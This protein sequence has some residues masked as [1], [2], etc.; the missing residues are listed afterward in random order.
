MDLLGKP[1]LEGLFRAAVAAAEPGAMVRKALRRS[2]SGLSLTAGGVSSGLDLDDL[3]KIYLVGGGKATR[4]MGEAA[5][6]ILGERVAAGVLAVPRGSGGGKGPVRFVEAGHPLPDE[7][8]RRAAGEM[9]SLLSEAGE[10]D[11][12][13][14]L[15]SGGGSAM[16]SAP[17]EGITPADKE[18][19][20]SL[21]LRLGVNIAEFNTIRKHLSLV[22]GGRMAKAAHPARVWALLLSDVPG[23]DPSVIASGPFSPDPTTYA[24]AQKI[25]IERRIWPD[26][27]RAVRTHIESGV[28]GRLPETPKRG[29]SIFGKVTCA[30]VGSNRIALN[31]VKAAAE[32][33]GAA[34]ARILPGFL[35][36][37]ARECA[38]AFVSELRAAS[39]SVPAGQVVV[40]A[41]GGEMT[42][43]VRGRGK[44]GRN[45]EFALAAAIELDGA[46][47]VAVLSAGTD[48][49][50][51]P[52][53]AAGA[54]VRGDTC[55]RARAA[56]LVPGH[57]LAGNDSHPLF[58][59]LS[60]LV[61][62]GPTGTNVTDVAIGV[63]VGTRRP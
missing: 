58:R 57:H 39:T 19:V 60:D 47:G 51:G 45:Q 18:V 4:A 27:P 62:T 13:I 48:G 20:L 43:T 17:A 31:A 63:A 21:L 46:E 34:V 54:Y 44:G 11:L 40:L 9:L 56:G 8:S 25:L 24:E 7:G 12:A 29:D 61:T 2:A 14:A 32:R 28:G 1:F 15:I 52:T 22:K 10:D 5:M 42:V 16:I 23:D 3:R 33:E 37:E 35:R 30:V 55:A 50:D 6:R 49:V 53:D 38:R 36:G 26:I 59:G 41:A